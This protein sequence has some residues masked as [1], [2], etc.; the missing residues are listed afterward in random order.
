MNR[1]PS[2]SSSKNKRKRTFLHRRITVTG[3]KKW[4]PHETICKNYLQT[5]AILIFLWTFNSRSIYKNV[6]LKEIIVEN[7][8][9]FVFKKEK[10]KAEKPTEINRKFLYWRLFF[11]FQQIFAIIVNSIILWFF[12][13]TEFPLICHVIFFLIFINKWGLKMN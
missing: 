9:R 3:G 7:V 2:S 5:T 12:F 11:F 1:R 4:Q 8:Y 13:F 6:F 10:K